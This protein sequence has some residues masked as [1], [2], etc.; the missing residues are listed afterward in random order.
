MSEENIENDLPLEFSTYSLITVERILAYYKVPLSSEVKLALK[1]PFTFYNHLIRLPLKNVLNG[2]TLQQAYDYQVYAQKLFIDYLLSGETR[3][4][5]EAPG[6]YTRE[7]LETER[8]DLLKLTNG[9][10]EQQLMHEKLIAEIQKFL[11]K[12]AKNWNKTLSEVATNIKNNLQQLNMNDCSEQQIIEGMNILLTEYNFDHPSLAADASIWVTL[13][14]IITLPL[15]PQVQQLFKEGLARLE[16]NTRDVETEYANYE[17]KITAMTHSIKECITGFYN[18]I[19]KTNELL[20]QL[21]DY[22]INNVQIEI[23][24]QELHFDANIEG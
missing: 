16:K 2:I 14:K 23:N 11:I 20:Q 19:V 12:H 22:R 8:L 3:K 15:T 6:S 13:E 9:F 21:P 18:A 24:K 7:Q 17:S 4:L 1:K 5:E 10:N